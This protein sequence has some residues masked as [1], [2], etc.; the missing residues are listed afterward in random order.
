MAKLGGNSH[1]GQ[2]RVQFPSY[3]QSQA[4]S[5]STPRTPDMDP[6]CV[7]LGDLMSTKRKG[8]SDVIFLCVCAFLIQSTTQWIINLGKMRQKLAYGCEL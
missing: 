1:N 2:P 3:L 7:H 8:K 4:H 5:L 6:S